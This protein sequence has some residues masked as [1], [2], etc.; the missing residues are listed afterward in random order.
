MTL[1]SDL[2]IEALVHGVDG[3]GGEGD[4]EDGAVPEEALNGLEAE[5]DADRRE[6]VGSKPVHDRL[7]RRLPNL[8]RWNWGVFVCDG[9]PNK[10][11]QVAV[12]LL[13]A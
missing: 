11:G 6:F 8:K 2:N 1:G 5:E 13:T 9:P 3:E 12:K 7:K 10:S 4:D